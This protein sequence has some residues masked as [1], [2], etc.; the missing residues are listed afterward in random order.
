MKQD[1]QQIINALLSYYKNR[2]DLISNK[3]VQKLKELFQKSDELKIA[4]LKK[5]IGK[6]KI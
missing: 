4:K 1:K 3:K 6:T 2:I 5:E